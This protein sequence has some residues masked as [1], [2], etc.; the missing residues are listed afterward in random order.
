MSIYKRGETWWIQFTAP[1]GERIQ[2]SARTTDK[3]QAQELHDTLKAESWRVKEL[4]AKPRYTWQ[5][6][7]VR[8]LTEKSDK[9]SLETDKFHLRWLNDHLSD[10]Y[11]DEI[12]KL[13][14]DSI[15]AV[16]KSEGVTNSTVN[17]ILLLVR[18]ILNRAQNEWQWI[19][20][21]PNFTR[22]VEPQI[23][24]RFLTQDEFSRLLNEL[25]AHLK[26]M[27]VFSLA[28]G[29]RESNVTRLEWSQ[30]D[31]QRQILSVHADDAKG[32]KT[33][34]IPL[35]TDAMAILN[36]QHGKHEQ[37]VFTYKSKPIKK[38][39]ARAWKAALKRAGIDDFTYH[40][41]RHTFASWHVQNGTP[42]NVLKE[43]GAWADYD[44]VLKYA[45]LST[46][47]L[48]SHSDNVKI[49]TK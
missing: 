20:K 8:W 41:L 28:T 21:V 10:K 49:V 40:D 18:A 22:L 47:H 29:L 46:E 14:L 31:M 3:Q 35:N 27:V 43:L 34:S 24:I 17:R 39:G 38:A 30:V 15:G 44:T 16:K 11:L 7:V 6:A 26:A 45:H 2:R 48:K 1:S 23:R 4:G 19:D 25:P 9:R 5:Q 32:K 37:F 12:T 33:F 36:E 13:M 42:L